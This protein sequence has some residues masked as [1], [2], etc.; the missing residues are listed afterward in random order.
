[1]KEMEKVHPKLPDQFVFIKDIVL[2][3]GPQENQETHGNRP[4]NPRT[5][6]LSVGVA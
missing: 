5:E 6:T 3:K 4:R 1:M 2:S